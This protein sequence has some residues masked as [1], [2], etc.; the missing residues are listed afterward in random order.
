MTKLSPSPLSVF[1]LML[2]LLAGGMPGAAQGPASGALKVGDQQYEL[3]YV[4]AV[5]VPQTFDETKQATR[6]SLSDLPVSEEAL[7][8]RLGISKL[9]NKGGFHGVT[10]EIGDE[11]SYVSMNLWSS[12]HDVIVSM[13]GTMDELVLS[14]QTDSQISGAVN[15][16]SNTVNGMLF[17]V[18]AKFAAP[19]KAQPATPKADVKKGTAAAELESVKTYLAM[20][21]AVRSADMETI[22]RLARYPQDFEG[23]DGEKFVKL[24]QTEEPLNLEVL[25]ASEAGDTATLTVSGVLEGKPISRKFEMKKAEGKWSTKNDNWQS[26]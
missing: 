26:N 18:S 22:R 25:E 19:V 12:D 21:K 2:L 6:L 15:G 20:R 4:T 14:S 23:A 17:Q 9:K 8:D 10:F 11:R 7:R 24:M 13:S 1:G 16:L 5:R 3:K